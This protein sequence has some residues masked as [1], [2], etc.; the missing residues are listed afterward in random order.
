MSEKIYIKVQREFD[1]P[2]EILWETIA[3]KFGKVSNYNPQ[4]NSS[5]LVGELSPGIGAVR[6]CVPVEGGF[7]KEEIIEWEELSDF[8][9]KLIDSSF[10]MSII[11]SKFSFVNEHGKTIVLQ[12]FWFKLKPP[13]GWFSWILK[14][15]M[16]ETLVAGLKGL[17][18]YLKNR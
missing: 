11:E 18:E 6:Y 9:L 15:K 16:T 12:E 3:A 7:L 13:F 8:K 5:R 4:I 14:G 2:V 17:D 10:P 1:F